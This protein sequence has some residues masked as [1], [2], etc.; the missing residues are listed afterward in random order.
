MT[1]GGNGFLFHQHCITY[2]AVFSLG[3]AGLGTGGG[4]CCI[5]Y[6]GMTR[7]GNSFLFRQ[8]CITYA[9]VLSFGFTGLG[10]GGCNGCICYL[11]VTRCW[12]AL[13]LLHGLSTGL[14]FLFRGIT[15]FCT[16]IWHICLCLYNVIFIMVCF[17]DHLL[18]YE[19]FIAE[20]THLSGCQTGLCTGSRLS[21]D[22]F[23]S[24]TFGRSIWIIYFFFTI[25]VLSAK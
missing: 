3:Q 8:H 10:A 24:V 1:R 17:R 23:G 6:L 16:G 2:A 11:F 22:C 12:D 14:A 20:Q 19:H 25:E 18:F 4:N 5:R 9:A 13:P 15:I 21:P 7:G